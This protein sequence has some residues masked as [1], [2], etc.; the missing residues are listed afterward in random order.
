MKKRIIKVID[1]RKF[2]G[3]II[4]G[5]LFLAFILFFT[6][7]Y[8][9]WK[10]ENKEV[11]LNINDVSTECVM[12]SNVN[13]TNIG[14]VLNY[15]DGVKATFSI[16]NGENKDR[17]ISLSLN[18]TSISSTLLV[19]YFKYILVVD[20]NGG[21]TYD[22][23][24][25][26]L[27]GDFSS[28][29]VGSNLITSSLTVTS[30]S[31]YSYQFIVYIDGSIYNNTNIQENS[32]VSNIALGNCGGSSTVLASTYVE[33]LYN[34]GSLLTSANIGGSDDN[35]SVSLN[36]TQGI[37]LDNNG[38]YRYYGSNP[39]NYV[40][41][42]N[43]LW[44][45]VSVSNVKSSTSDS[46]GEKRVKIIRNESIGNYSW[47]SSD[48][49]INSGQGVNDWTQ[50]DLMTELNTLY[51]NQQ[52]GT[53]YTGSSNTSGTCDFTS[54]GL[55]ETSKSLIDNALWYLGGSTT[56]SGLYSDDYYNF[57]RGTTVYGCSTD[58]GACPRAT[59]WVGKVA[60]IYPSDF[61]YAAGS[62]TWTSNNWLFNSVQ[63]FF[64]SPSASYSQIVFGF[65]Q[66][67]GFTTNNCYY[68][69]ATYPSV[70]LKADVLIT[71]G[72]GESSDP[73]LLSL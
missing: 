20:V 33:N 72:S 13:A 63:K 12:G 58:D 4:G 30:M 26:V 15:Q 67:G 17:T 66:S 53:C 69:N 21:T 27:T 19:D 45:I 37:M 46:T 8:Y 52:S 41:F 22:Y 54:I 1:I 29:Q 49:S 14:P 42:N 65:F 43:E 48:S 18:I 10:S 36:E 39:N 25:P 3:S 55:N 24:N 47:D 59:T 57:E 6:Y 60:L 11:I 34:D 73:Y 9:N 32:L 68:N 7:A 23:N 61:S 2:F 35:P 70:Y 38:E 16:E 71:D 44:R 56:T 51:Y 28:F 31:T 50:A 5:V 40:S 62:G 64:L